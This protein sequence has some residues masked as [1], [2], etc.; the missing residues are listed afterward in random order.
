[1]LSFEKMDL[2]VL[3]IRTSKI[4]SCGLSVWLCSLKLLMLGPNYINTIC[5]Q[6]NW[7]AIYCREVLGRVCPCGANHVS[8]HS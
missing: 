3:R 8:K 4:V 1:M 5:F 7:L 6:I 2:S